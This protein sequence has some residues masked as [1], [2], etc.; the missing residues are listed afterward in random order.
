MFCQNCGTKV[1]E[2][3]AFCA[4]CGCL[5]KGGDV[6]EHENLIHL[7]V[8]VDTSLYC[9]ISGYLGLFAVLGIFAPLAVIFGILGLRESKKKKL[10]GALRAYF[11]LSSGLIFLALYA[12]LFFN[13]E[14]WRTFFL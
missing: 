12:I 9:I 8:P 2:N 13:I 10:H 1:D 3:A 11:A 14:N 5:L 4:K 7:L 6:M